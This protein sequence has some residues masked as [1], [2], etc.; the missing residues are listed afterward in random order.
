MLVGEIYTHL[1]TKNRKIPPTHLAKDACRLAIAG[2]NASPAAV[3]VA[4]DSTQL[5][6]YVHGVEAL[7]Y[8]TA[9]ARLIPKLDQL[10]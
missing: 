7:P 10:S 2:M 4:V 6:D 5:D 1:P 9:M 8:M 3:A